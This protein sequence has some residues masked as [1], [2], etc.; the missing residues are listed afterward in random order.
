M[1]T[2]LLPATID[3]LK[4]IVYDFARNMGS[5]LISKACKS[6]RARLMTTSVVTMF[7]L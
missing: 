5:E 7:I 3:D 2:E 1:S 6:P 4:S